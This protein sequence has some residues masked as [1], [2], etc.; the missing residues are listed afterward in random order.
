M[1]VYPAPADCAFFSLHLIYL[2]FFG[3]SAQLTSAQMLRAEH[4]HSAVSPAAVSP[5]TVF[6]SLEASD[7]AVSLDFFS[8]PMDL[9]LHLVHQQEVEI[10]KV[11]MR[12]IAEQYLSVI[13]RAQMVDLEKASEYLVIAATLLSLKS[14]SMLP[15]QA[16]LE[17]EAEQ[18]NSEQF[19]EELRERLRQYEITK[20]RARALVELPQLGVD[21]YSR[22]DRRALQPTPEMLAEP[23]EVTSMGL[24]FARLLKRIGG[25]MKSYRVRL[26]SISVVSYMMKIV[27]SLGGMTEAKNEVGSLPAQGRRTF[28]SLLSGFISTGVHDKKRESSAPGKNVASLADEQKGIVIGSFIAVLELVKRGFIHAVQPSDREE[29]TLELSLA[30]YGPMESEF[31]LL[32]AQREDVDRANQAGVQHSSAAPSNIVPFPSGSTAGAGSALNDD[33]EEEVEEVRLKEANNRGD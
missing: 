13:A 11:S 6:P 9:L 4:Q 7:F 26:E 18:E 22:N 5:A 21:V 10:E 27:D 28:S 3:S 30:G 25:A 23:E 33:P 31:D 12:L 14:A 24:L 29:I 2:K 16:E 8:G 19:Y 1:E 20:R 15:Q 32:A 17:S